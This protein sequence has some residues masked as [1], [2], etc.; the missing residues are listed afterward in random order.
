MGELNVFRDK[1]EEYAVQWGSIFLIILFTIRFKTYDNSFE[2]R[3]CVVMHNGKFIYKCDS[4]KFETA[5]ISH[6]SRR[7]L[8]HNNRS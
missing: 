6:V 5:F 3:S 8:K 4:R 7:Y 2:I 1:M